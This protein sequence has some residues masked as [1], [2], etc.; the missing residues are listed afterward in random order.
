MSRHRKFLNL[1]LA[2]IV[3][4]SI[5]ILLFELSLTQALR[6][7]MAASPLPIEA[8]IVDWQRC[9]LDMMGGRD[10]HASRCKIKLPSASELHVPAIIASPSIE[11]PKESSMAPLW[12]LLAGLS[13]P[14]SFGGAGVL[15]FLLFRE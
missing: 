3:A 1:C 2:S 9:A 14:L 6:N 4:A 7:T 15:G 11:M 8:Q 12:F 10:A 13:F 5:G